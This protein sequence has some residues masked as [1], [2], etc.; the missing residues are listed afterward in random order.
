M[1]YHPNFVQAAN[2]LGSV[3]EKVVEGKESAAEKVT[4]LKEATVE[5]VNSVKEL[6]LADKLDAI[7]RDHDGD[8]DDALTGGDLAWPWLFWQGRAGR[9]TGFE[10]KLDFHW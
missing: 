6:R 2:I 1:N 7:L 5:K 10:L 9:V 4:L 8:H 3:K